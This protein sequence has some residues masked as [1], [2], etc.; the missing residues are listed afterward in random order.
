VSGVDPAAARGRLARPGPGWLT[1]YPA[2][3]GAVASHP[4]LELGPGDAARRV[5]AAGVVAV[6]G[7]ARVADPRG[8]S[9]P[10]GQRVPD[11]RGPPGQR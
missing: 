8:Q 9:G 7:G 4:E 11:V 1:D 10:Q 5:G 6:R 2:L 3:L